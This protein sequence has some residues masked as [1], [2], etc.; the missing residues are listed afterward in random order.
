[1]IHASRVQEKEPTQRKD[2]RLWTI[3]RLEA[4]GRKLEAKGSQVQD[5]GC[6]LDGECKYLLPERNRSG[7]RS[8]P[9]PLWRD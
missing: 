1:M 5:R 6:D 8:A 2:P 9:S 7:R 4:R 3:W